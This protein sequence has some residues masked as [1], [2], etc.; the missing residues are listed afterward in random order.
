[1]NAESTAQTEQMFSRL[2]IKFYLKSKLSQKKILVEDMILDHHSMNSVGKM[3]YHGFTFFKHLHLEQE[4]LPGLAEP[5][6][7]MKKLKFIAVV[8]AVIDKVSPHLGMNKMDISK[9]VK[10]SG[11]YWVYFDGQKFD[12]AMQK[13]ISSPA[14]IH[15]S[16]VKQLE[17]SGQ[18]QRTGDEAIDASWN[19][20]GV[21]YER[22]E[23]GKVRA[24]L[25]FMDCRVVD[26]N[27]ERSV[28]NSLKAF[29]AA[30]GTLKSPFSVF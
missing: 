18:M 27:G 11:G 28:I 7:W 14:I 6:Y 3:Q 13:T 24:W 26:V 15:Q 21:K 8:Q 4:I 5:V 10:W 9:H 29:S 16:R 19:L 12:S 1:L 22:L 30:L 17:Q 20:L 2:I 25:P 23:G